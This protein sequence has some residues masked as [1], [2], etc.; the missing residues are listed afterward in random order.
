MNESSSSLYSSLHTISNY[1][2]PFKIRHRHRARGAAP[3]NLLESQIRYAMENTRTCQEAARWLNIDY[4]TFKRYAIL[5]IDKETG[6]NLFDLHRDNNASKRRAN[7]EKIRRE[8]AALR[9]PSSRPGG[10]FVAYPIQDILDNKQ[11]EKYRDLVLDSMCCLTLLFDGICFVLVMPKIKHDNY[12]LHSTKGMAMKWDDGSG[13]YFLHGVRLDKELWKKI[14]G[15]KMTFKEC[16]EISN[17]E[18]R[19]VA[20]REMNADKMLEG[21]KAKKISTSKYGYEL[22]RIEKIFSQTAYFLKYK[23]TS[24]DRIYITGINFFI[25]VKCINGIAENFFLGYP[26]R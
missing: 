18:L 19:M 13:L 15:G 25:A 9:P 3:L 6:K 11:Y 7:S 4:N 12:K 10:R 26:I 8:K 24:T 17:V 16:M 14:V 5:Y 20:L 1:G 22:Y 23:C 21:A 2:A